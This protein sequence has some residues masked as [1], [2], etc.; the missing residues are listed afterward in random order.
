MINLEVD[1]RGLAEIRQGLRA[2]PVL[3]AER[4]QGDGFRAA[5]GAVATRAKTVVPVKSGALRRSIKARR[6]SE[7][8]LTD[9]GVRR[10]PGAGARVTSGGPGARHAVFVEYG[11]R[12]RQRRDARSYLRRAIIETQGQLFNIISARMSRSFRKIE[13][14]QL[15][16]LQQRLISQSG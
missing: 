13:Q 8:V 9:R 16:R 15:N 1:S 7:R 3:L 4:V 10:V 6:I 2:L 12:P 5:A 14:G 11:I